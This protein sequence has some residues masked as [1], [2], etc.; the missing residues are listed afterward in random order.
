MSKAAISATYVDYRRVKGRKVHQII[1]EVPSEKWPEA[2]GVLGEPTIET[3]EWFAVAKM[4]GAEPVQN[5]GGK[6]A[7]RAGILCGEG[8]FKAFCAEKLCHADP[9]QAIYERCGVTSRAHLDH[10]DQ[11]AKAFHEM[12]VEY[13]AWRIAA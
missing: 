3:S 12:T 6:L 11:A 13:D 5:K 9:A 4:N 1:F 8:A 7:Q 10:D 2:Y